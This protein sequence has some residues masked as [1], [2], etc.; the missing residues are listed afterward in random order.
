MKYEEVVQK[1]IM[2]IKA[3][4]F[5]VKTG[6]RY[7]FGGER[8]SK[9]LPVEIILPLFKYDKID[10]TDFFENQKNYDLSIC[11]TRENDDID[12]DIVQIS[13]LLKDLY[14]DECCDESQFPVILNKIIEVKKRFLM[15]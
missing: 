5:K 12:K 7:V 14:S 3:N 11:R 4:G 13:V 2:F 10:K 15:N 6:T 9:F 8:N 1:F